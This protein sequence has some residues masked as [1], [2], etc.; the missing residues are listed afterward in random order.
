MQL[1]LSVVSQGPEGTLMNSYQQPSQLIF[2]IGTPL[3]LLPPYMH[4]IQILAY[5]CVAIPCSYY[6]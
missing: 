5:L 2:D 6:L 3:V 1:E 4:I